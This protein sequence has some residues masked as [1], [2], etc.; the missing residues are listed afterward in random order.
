MHGRRPNQNVQ[1]LLSIGVNQ[2]ITSLAEMTLQVDGQT[3]LHWSQTVK[4]ILAMESYNAFRGHDDERLCPSDPSAKPST[5]SGIKLTRPIP[6]LCQ[7]LGYGFMSRNDWSLQQKLLSRRQIL[8]RDP[9]RFMMVT[10]IICAIV[11]NFCTLC[12]MVE[13]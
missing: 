4:A 13:K 9:T 12:L 10:G 11:G 8:T 6:G 7:Q 3:K 1:V 5:W 2:M